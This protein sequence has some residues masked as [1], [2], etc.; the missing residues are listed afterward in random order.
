[1]VALA[2]MLFSGKVMCRALVTVVDFG[3]VYVTTPFAKYDG[4]A[5]STGMYQ[6]EERH[7]YV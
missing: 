3:G 7:E 6:S 5:T 2:A 1:M 4:T